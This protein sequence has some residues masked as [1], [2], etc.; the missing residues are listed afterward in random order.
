MSI[1]ST[2]SDRQTGL[3]RAMKRSNY[4]AR[5][6]VTASPYSRRGAPVWLWRLRK[7]SRSRAPPGATAA[8]DQTESVRTDVTDGNRRQGAAA[9]AVP[10]AD[11]GRPS[12]SPLDDLRRTLDLVREERH[13]AAHG[14]YIQARDR[15]EEGWAERER[16]EGK[17]AKA[18][19]NSRPFFRGRRTN[20]S[21]SPND[22]LQLARD[23]LEEK[24][25]EFALLR[26]RASLF[27]A[28]RETL[29]QHD[30]DV[31]EESDESSGWVHAQT[32]FG[33]STHYR[34]EPDGSLSIR[35]AGDLV[36]V[37]LFEQLAVLREV[38]LYHVWAPFCVSSRKLA[39]LGRL[40][41]AAW[42]DV[43]APMFGLSRD[44]CYR[45][46]GC[47]GMAED[48][49]VM[50]VAVG[51]NDTEEHGVVS[52]AGLGKQAQ[53]RPPS[54]P[55]AVSEGAEDLRAA[56]GSLLSS[57]AKDEI[58]S[59]LEMPPVPSG[60]GRGRMTIR[61]FSARVDVLGPTSA[62]TIMVVN[63]DPNLQLM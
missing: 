58:L 38:D 40:D 42:Y 5:P 43:G 15:V 10:P 51:L 16:R 54:P 7:A 27:L 26:R 33:V 37:P 63:I 14:L 31:G 32:L 25:D 1:V 41:V 62:R 22:E 4:T 48:G 23:F 49:S 13:L 2:S 34:R 17:S 39:Q 52:S 3:A 59:T 35:I 55:A 53:K 30:N 11:D 50:I 45:A 20:D 18:R 46:V 9:A 61:N 8:E 19:Q 21:G 12:A 44:A 57:L 6:A 29:S 60:V 36:G 47:D 28:A 24:S 56:E